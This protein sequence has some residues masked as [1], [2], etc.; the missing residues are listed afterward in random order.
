GVIGDGDHG[1]AAARGSRGK[2]QADGPDGA[3][4]QHA[5][6]V[7]GGKG[8]VG[9]IGA[10]QGDGGDGQRRRAA[11]SESKRLGG[12]GRVHH[13]AAEVQARVVQRDRRRRGQ[14]AG[15]GQ[16]HQLRAVSRVIEEGHGG[17]AAARG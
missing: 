15:A 8:E 13:L 2:R 17:L 12:A 11:V 7:A 9:R 16:R 1:A 3:G 6:R 14:V 4:G 5:A 10:G